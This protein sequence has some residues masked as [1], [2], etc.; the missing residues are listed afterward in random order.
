MGIKITRDEY[1]DL[2]LH[3]VTGL[4]S[5]EEMYD[6]LENFYKREPTAL[7]LWDMSQADVSHV[8]PD[9]LQKFV[10]KSTELAVRRQGGGR[11]AVVAS[12]DL[13]YGLARMSGVFAEME[14]APY[15]FSAFRS[16]QEA[17]QW[18]KSGDIS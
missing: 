1:Q 15:S 2:T 4:V 9:I 16:R 14:S 3:D 11:I 13:Q 17:L 5:E 7:L 6:A 8:T 12:E 10:R 18:L